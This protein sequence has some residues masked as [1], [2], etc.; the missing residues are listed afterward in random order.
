MKLTQE[1]EDGKRYV[2]TIG[3]WEEDA[4]KQAELLEQERKRREKNQA[5]T[6]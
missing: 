2:T 4:K 6:A 5:S 1:R 3:T